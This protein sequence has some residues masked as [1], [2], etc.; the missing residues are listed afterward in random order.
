MGE[1]TV[2]QQTPKDVR[3]NLFVNGLDLV[4]FTLG[5]SLV[6]R[7]TVM[8]A[9][10]STLTDSKLAIGLIPAIFSLSY[11]LPQL[12]VANFSERLRYKKPFVMLIA[13]PGERGAY[14][15]IALVIWLLA[16]PSPELALVLFFLLLAVGGI[17]SG[18]VTPAW[19]DIIAKTVPVQRRGRWAGISNSLG[20]FCAVGGALLVGQILE[21]RAYPDNFALIFLLAFAAWLVSYLGL[22]LIRE[23]PSLAVKERIPLVRYLGQ[24]P[25]ILRADHN[26]R[27]FL[28]SRST[29]HLGALASGFF[30]VYGQ[31]RFQVDGADIGLFTAVL[32][33][34][35]ALMNLLWGALAD[36]AGHK[37]ILSIAPFLMALAV[38]N[39]WLAPAGPWLLLTFALVGAYLAAENVSA[40]NI[41]VEFAAEENL[42]TY[43]GLT[44]TLLAP[45]LTLAPILGGWLATSR[46]YGGLFGTA[47]TVAV[48]GGLLTLRWVREPRTQS[49]GEINSQSIPYSPE[50]S[51]PGE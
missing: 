29:V 19:Y 47:V 18:T 9:L 13:G 41:I 4:F 17:C 46:G 31:E 44:N 32:V 23:P 7:E 30:V 26:Y 2:V 11:Y 39:T 16:E 25:A 51:V 28:I 49:R 10:V 21:R 12:L 22:A 33:G 36:R 5:L 14:L 1:L 3:W 37:L 45:M 15:L 8:P 35:Q 27:R 42:P 43:I 50:M 20:A 24:L 6:S 38:I 40:F 48:L 34:S